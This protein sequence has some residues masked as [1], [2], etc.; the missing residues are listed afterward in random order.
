MNTACNLRPSGMWGA[1]G[2][3]RRILLLDLLLEGREG[4]LLTPEIRLLLVFLLL[5]L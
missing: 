4:G 2:K 1:V 5:R 3:R